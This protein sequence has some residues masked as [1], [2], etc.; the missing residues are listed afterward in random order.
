MATSRD[1]K[2]LR[3]GCAALTAFARP[4]ARPIA[5]TLAEAI[6]LRWPTFPLTSDGLLEEDD[7][8][9]P[10]KGTPSKGLSTDLGAKTAIAIASGT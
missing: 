9:V 3:G 5:T 1:A 7:A 10:C 2:I 6:T 4:F 8:D